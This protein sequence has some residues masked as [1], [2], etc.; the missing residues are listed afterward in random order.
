MAMRIHSMQMAALT[1]TAQDT[2]EMTKMVSEKMAATAESAMA[3]N[4]ALANAAFSAFMGAATGR[5]PKA[6]KTGEKLAAAA[7]TPY[8]KRVR[9]NARRLARKKV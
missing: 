2:A 9:S 3:V 6:S 5:M 1:G 7:L 4:V 8:G